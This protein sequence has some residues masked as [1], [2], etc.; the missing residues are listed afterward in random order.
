VNRVLEP[1]LLD[2]LP[3]DDPR[4]LQSRRDLHRI[5]WWMRNPQILAS[6]LRK[7]F[8]QAP[9]R[10]AD[11]GAGDGDFSV[12]VARQLSG[13]WE[14]I[15]LILLD[16]KDAGAGAIDRIKQNH[17]HAQ[18]VVADVFEWLDRKDQFD[19]IYTNLFLHHFSSEQLEVLFEKI[20]QRTNYFVACEPRRYRFSG[21]IRFLLWIIGCSQVTRDDGVISVRAGFRGNELTKLWPKGSGWKIVERRGGFLSHVFEAQKV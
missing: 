17:W 12:Q 18:F 7:R 19:G 15:E 14:N 4:A 5:N 8:T 9:R 1:E 6:S 11:I 21:A 3:P 16:R 2:E 10:L 20:S 13:K